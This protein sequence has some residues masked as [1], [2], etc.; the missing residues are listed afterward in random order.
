M[1]VDVLSSNYQPGY[2]DGETF[3]CGKRALNA[4]LRTQAL[5]S[6][7]A[8]NT[9]VTVWTDGERR[10]ILGY[11]ALTLVALQRAELRK[12]DTGGGYSQV[13][14][15]LI[16]RLAL[17]ERLHG[18]GLGVDLLRDA[19]LRVLAAREIAGGRLLVVD[20]IDED[21]HR[22]Y[23]HNGFKPLA[24]DARLIMK[25]DDIEC[26]TSSLAGNAVTEPRSGKPGRA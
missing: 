24:D 10:E 12:A 5:R 23:V 11:Y 4:W 6:Q 2:H 9:Q 21:A 20:A 3:N 8:G 17:D 19:Q 26:S 22:F 16:A 14:G 7:R 15:Y 13:P 1:R 18:Q 25:L